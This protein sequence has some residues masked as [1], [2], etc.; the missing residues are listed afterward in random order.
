MAHTLEHSHTDRRKELDVKQYFLILLL[1]TTTCSAFTPQDNDLFARANECYAQAAYDEAYK[2]YNEVSSP[3]P[4]VY[5]NLGTCAFKLNKLGR[6]LWHFRQAQ[7]R[8]G[9]FDRDDLY[10]HIA[11]IRSKLNVDNATHTG[12]YRQL[13][14]KTS[15]IAQAIPLIVIQLL[16]LFAWTSLFVFAKKLFKKRLRLLLITFFGCII[17]LGALLLWRQTNALQMRAIVIEP[18][19]ITLHSGPAASYQKIGSL[20]EGSEL[21]IDQQRDDFCKVRSHTQFGWVARSTLGFI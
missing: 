4:R 15:N 1:L 13:R 12:L 20:P 10:E 9:F 21:R 17:M 11:L 6:A 19:G 18:K 14:F 7:A 5:F 3:T 16:F 2:L 8:W